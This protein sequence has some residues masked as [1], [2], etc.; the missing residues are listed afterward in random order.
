M[1][2]RAPPVTAV[3]AAYNEAAVI[4][5][6]LAAVS[7]SRYSN[8]VEIIVIDDGSTDRTAD[9]VDAMAVRDRRIRL[10]RR[11]NGGKP[12]ALNRAFVEARTDVVVTLDADTLLRSDTVDQL[13]RGFADDSSGSLGAVA[14]RVKVGNL[15]N[16][17]TRWQALE[18]LIQ[19]GVDRSA[20]NALRAIMVV[21]GACAAWRREAVLRVG[22]YSSQTLAEDCDLVLALHQRGYRVLQNDR[23]EAFTEAPETFRDLSRQRFRWTFGNTQALWKHRSMILNLRYGWLGMFTL[24]TAAISIMLP[25]VFLPFVYVMTVMTIQSNNEAM[26]VTYAAIFLAVQSVQAVAGVALSRENPRHLLIVPLY[27]LIAEPLRAYL[28]YK[29]AFTALRGT[30]SRWNKVA[31]TGTAQILATTGAEVQR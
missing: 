13:A 30:R 19:I 6:C 10:I 18:Y 31:R 28:L 26:L 21:P 25:V 14:G 2:S 3:V 5:R 15:R 27:R 4:D 8:L 1:G 22:G 9:I 7:R 17:L 29:S 24:P 20:Q 12:S 23:A 16:L 11:P